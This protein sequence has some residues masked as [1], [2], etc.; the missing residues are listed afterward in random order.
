MLEFGER[1]RFYA[2]TQ[3]CSVNGD[4][5]PRLQ[6]SLDEFCTLVQQAIDELPAA[7]RERLDNVVV[8][9]EPTP[10][11][12][13]LQELGIKRGDSLMGLFQGSPITEQEYGAPT[14]NRVVLYQRSIE[15]ACRSRAEI[16][17]EVRR[18]VLHE[19]GHHFGYSE[20]DL[21][22]FEE[23]PSPFDDDGPGDSRR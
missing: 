19:L 16:A 18:T 5:M 20:E 10:P 2:V 13:L 11:A 12:H 4:S 22:F 7:F 21:D 8:D 23:R 9:V 3:S 17:Y 14:P 6:L 15:G 1:H